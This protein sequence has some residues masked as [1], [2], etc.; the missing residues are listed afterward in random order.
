[1]IKIKKTLLAAGLATTLGLSQGCAL[2]LVGGLAAGVVY[3][4][5][6]YAKNTLQVTDNVSLGRAWQAANGA[7]K[8]LSIPVTLSKKDGTSG[9]LEGRNIKN[10]PVIIVLTRQTDGVTNIDVTVGTFDSKE[11]RDDAQY[12]YDRMKDRF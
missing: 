8:D 4:T 2:L 3:G 7:M 9:R 1:M 10:Q 11:N 5:V 12:L 6:S